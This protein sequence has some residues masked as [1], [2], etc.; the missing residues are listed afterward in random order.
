MSARSNLLRFG[1]ALVL[2]AVVTHSQTP[3]SQT[4]VTDGGIDPEL[5]EKA[6]LGDP[7]AEFLVSVAYRKGQGVPMNQ[8][9]SASWAR[10]AA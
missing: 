4:P 1:V 10:K 7:A 5:I 9:L 8:A 3:V 2:V 6:K